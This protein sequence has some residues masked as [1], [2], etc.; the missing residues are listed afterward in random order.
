M[1]QPGGVSRFTIDLN[2]AFCFRTYPLLATE[3]SVTKH[4]SLGAFRFGTLS[5]GGRKFGCQRSQRSFARW[6]TS[7]CI[8]AGVFFTRIHLRDTTKTYHL[9]I[10]GKMVNHS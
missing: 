1:E 2:G 10:I 5:S 8:S 9:A 7:R 3:N 6:F 4:H